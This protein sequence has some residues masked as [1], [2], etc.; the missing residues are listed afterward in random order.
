[1]IRLFPTMAP[2]SHKERTPNPE[3]SIIFD[4]DSRQTFRAGS[5]VGGTIILISSIARQLQNAE[6]VFF[7]HQVT[8]TT[9]TEKHFDSKTIDYHDDAAFF[10]FAQLLTRDMFVDVGRTY[11]WKF[12]FYFPHVASLDRAHPYS[13]RIGASDVYDNKPHPLPPSF[14]QYRA[15]TRYATVEYST[16]A[17]FT[18]EGEKHPVIAN[19]AAALS[20]LPPGPGTHPP[21]LQEFSK[22]PQSFASSR[23][24]GST[25]SFRNSLTDKFSSATPAVEIVLKTSVPSLLDVG[26]KFP[27]YVCVE[28]VPTARPAEISLPEVI[29]RVKKLQLCRYTIYRALRNDFYTSA[30]NQEAEAADENAVPLNAVP[31]GRAVQQKQGVNGMWFYTATFEARV[32]GDICPSFSTFNINHTLRIEMVVEAEV[33][34][35]KFEFK[36]IVPDVV[37]LAPDA[38]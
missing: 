18:F 17:I 9:E 4:L 34:G 28:V 23:L 2:F 12:E 36:I 31:E 8:H 35:K 38:T 33:C 11:Q 29:V 32:P 37:V 7:G 20:F 27:I 30:F 3:I 10:R 25:K 14:T 26:G 24:S 1:M 16:H 13:G 5:R 19:P 15:D 22:P 6:V 21:N